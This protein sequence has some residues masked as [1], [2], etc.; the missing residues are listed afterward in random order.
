MATG[1]T[2]K[3]SPI[4]WF[5]GVVVFLIV[6][7][8][9]AALGVWM[10]GNAGN[11]PSAPSATLAIVLVVLGVIVMGMGLG[12]YGLVL[13]TNVFTFDFARPYFKSYGPKL[14]VANLIVGLLLQTGFAFVTAPT[15]MVGLAPLVPGSFLWIVS[16]FVPFMLAQLLL[17]WFTI[18]APLEAGIIT[19]RAAAKGIGPELLRTAHYVGISNPSNSSL[20]KL[21]VV[22]EDM[23]LLWIEP[24]ALMYR[25]DA[26]DWDLPRDQVIAVER[27]ADAGST[28]SYFG[29][30]HI[31]L[32]VAD[33]V[34]GGE[35][36]I[37]LHT[38]GDWTMSAKACALASLGDRLDSWKNSPAAIPS[39]LIT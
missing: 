21:T 16:F 34:T 2:A 6:A 25:G 5:F 8:G 18:W 24:H 13:L 3:L 33:P 15:L 17:I 35:R 31:V 14:W 30:V 11:A 39:S 7:V 9:C 32:H 28:S 1:S 26:I 22:E 36:R 38:E 19:K 10:S 12:L 23:G 20:K 4:K 29:A 37:R 27:R